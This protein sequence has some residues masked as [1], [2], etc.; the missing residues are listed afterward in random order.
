MVTNVALGAVADEAGLIVSE[1]SSS[2][3]AKGR[4]GYAAVFSIA[5]VR[6]FVLTVKA[7]VYSRHCGRITVTEEALHEWR[8]G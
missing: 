7:F 2:I 5:K 4:R 8:W 1:A 6:G 3:G